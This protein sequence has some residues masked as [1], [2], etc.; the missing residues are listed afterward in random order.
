M[1]DV[2]ALDPLA[3]RH[4]SLIGE[5]KS[6]LLVIDDAFAD[7]DAIVELAARAS[8][9]PVEGRG[10][11]YPGIRAPLPVAYAE[12]MA[13]L[14]GPDLETFGLTGVKREVTLNH[15]QIVTTRPEALALP[16]RVPHFDTMEPRQIA[17]LHYLTREDMGGTDFYRYRATG[18]ERITIDRFKPYTEHLVESLRTLGPPPQDYMRDEDRR[19]ERIGACEARFNRVVAYFS[20]ALHSGRIPA[21]ASLS[22]N[23]R[24]GRLTATTF[25]KYSA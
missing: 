14:L 2:F 22:A 10:N 8:F 24:E 3:T 19:Y 4:L 9:T 13:H 16:Q 25:L 17:L 23:A 12:A 6:P 20:N 21:A 1:A 18:D 7:P 15:L 11:H 5:Q